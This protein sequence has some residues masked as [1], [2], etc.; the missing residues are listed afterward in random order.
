M[1]KLLILAVSLQVEFLTGNDCMVSEEYSSRVNATKIN[2][3]NDGFG[4]EGG[5]DRFQSYLTEM[6]RHRPWFDF[7]PQTTAVVTEECTNMDTVAGDFA[8][9]GAKVRFRRRVAGR[10]ISHV[11]GTYRVDINLKYGYDG[12]SFHSAT[13]WNYVNTTDEWRDDWNCKTELNMHPSKRQFWQHNGE[14]EGRKHQGLKFFYKYPNF[15]AIKSLGDLISLFPS[16]ARILTVDPST[17]LVYKSC[18]FKRLYVNDFNLGDASL[19]AV[20]T[21]SYDTLEQ[22]E[23]PGQ[24]ARDV[25]F[26]FKVNRK[27]KEQLAQRHHAFELMTAVQKGQFGDHDDGPS[28]PKLPGSDVLVLYS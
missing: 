15:M 24:A 20:T 18:D 8:A 23:S 14:I 22:M 10:Y 21:F 12:D 1:A 13:D 2:E 9:A 6:K 25:Q 27:K 11:D 5:W 26:E 19:K 7:P 3:E 16:I 4:H 28:D 17:L